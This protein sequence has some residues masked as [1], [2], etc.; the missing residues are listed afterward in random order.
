MT[1]QYLKRLLKYDQPLPKKTTIPQNRNKKRQKSTFTT[2]NLEEQ[3]LKQI[4][5]HL[6][7]WVENE[8]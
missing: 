5:R 4:T 1:T 8:A 6:S 2:M 7:Y 3:L